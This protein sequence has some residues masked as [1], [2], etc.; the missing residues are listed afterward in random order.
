MQTRF[1]LMYSFTTTPLV[2][3]CHGLAVRMEE[4]DYGDFA[5]EDFL[6]A[7]SQASQTLPAHLGKRRREASKEDAD[8][9][10]GPLRRR[11]RTSEDGD[12]EGYGSEPPP[13][14]EE[15]EKSKKKRYRIHIAGREV[16][17]AIFMGATQ[18]EALPDSSPWR[19]RGPIYKK[20]RPE[21]SPPKPPIFARVPDQ[22]PPRETIVP[23]NANALR[24]QQSPILLHL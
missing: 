23:R 10:D 8:D 15:A 21:P 14:D 19:I 22:Y 20:P 2:G 16:P 7:F 24:Q 18:A 9:S 4:D 5:D 12:S 6:E 1:T 11:R 3:V 17:P 13:P